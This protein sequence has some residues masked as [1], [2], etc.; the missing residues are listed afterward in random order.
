MVLLNSLL[1]LLAAWLMGAAFGGGSSVSILTALV[2]GFCAFTVLRVG[3]GGRT[4]GGQGGGGAMEEKGDR[5]G[6]QEGGAGGLNTTLG[7]GI[8]P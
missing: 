1:A 8:F 2:L 5:R 7:I 3:R 4:K 6:G